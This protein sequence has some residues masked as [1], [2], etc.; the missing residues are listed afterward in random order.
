MIGQG[1]CMLPATAEQGDKVNRGIISKNKPVQRMLGRNM[2]IHFKEHLIVFTRYPEPGKT[3]TRLIPLLG[4]EGAADLQRKMTEHTLSQVK[5][6]SVRREL[7]VEIR[8]EG[9]DKNRMRTWLGRNF[10]YRPQSSGDLGQRMKCSLEDAFGAGASTA[11]IIGSDIPDMTNGII[12]K[13]FE[14]LQQKNM[15]LG[16]AKDG[17]YYL[18]GLQ[19]NSLSQA[20]P[21]LFRGITW[22]SGDVL[23][24]T[25]TIAKHS[26]LSYDLLD[27]LQDVDHPEDLMIRKRSQ[28]TPPG[29]FKPY[30]ISIII[31]AI[32]EADH[33]ANT[34][35]SIGPG[36]KKEVIVV[37]GGSNDHTV[38]IAK[39]L[40]AKVITSAPPRARQMNRGADQ[41]TGDVLVFLHA[42][43]RLPERFEDLI[44]NR[45]KHPEMVA[46]AFELRMDSP[47]PGL[48]LIEYLA[49]W[50]SR[51]LKIPYG[52]QAIF[53]SS[54]VFL[55]IGGF[56]DIPIMEDFELVRRLRKQG[57]IVTLSAPVFTSARRWRNFGILKT[58]LINQLVI[59]SYVMGIAPEV[60]ARW[61]D[62]SKGV[63]ERR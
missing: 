45:F 41:A 4:A 34:I 16:P 8:Y 53:I 61:Y 54:K 6:L 33:M 40:G 39:S 10:E 14:A 46:G 37:D 43:T 62:R 15:V 17:G 25:I 7:S 51:Y 9:G 52:D 55:E 44:F 57:N 30:R 59:I 27:V 13:A 49:N 60:I 36:N 1:F 24:K 63:S 18:I 50:R 31:P 22:G 11:V 20:I 35:K 3:K 38:E 5:R 12:Q 21:D 56:P 2:P 19:K 48:R 26:G 58:T 29:V 23:K 32:N 28:H 42:D 47:M